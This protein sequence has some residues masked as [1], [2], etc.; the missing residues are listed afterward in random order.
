MLV[1]LRV[2][3]A[4]QPSAC[5]FTFGSSSS[6]GGSCNSCLLSRISICSRRS[7]SCRFGSLTSLLFPLIILTFSNPHRAGWKRPSGNSRR[8]EEQIHASPKLSRHCSMLCGGTKARTNEEKNG[9]QRAE[10][11]VAIYTR[12]ARLVERSWFFFLATLLVVHSPLTSGRGRS[13]ATLKIIQITLTA[14]IQRARVLAT[15]SIGLAFTSSFLS[16]SRRFAAMRDIEEG[17]DGE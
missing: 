2:L 8:G 17:I 10:L 14:G 3:E 12:A 16:S 15:Y 5:I 6:S 1:Q 13:L 11:P 9:T 7:K 4:G